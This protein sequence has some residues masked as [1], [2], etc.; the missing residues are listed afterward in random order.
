MFDNGAKKKG[1]T[2]NVMQLPLGRTECDR[3]FVGTKNPID[4]YIRMY[5]THVRNNPKTIPI[6]MTPPR[7]KELRNKDEITAT[8]TAL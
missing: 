2:T 4:E 3:Y 5:N 1:V 8:P 6:K 7:S